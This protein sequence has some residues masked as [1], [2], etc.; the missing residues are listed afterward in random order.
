MTNLPQSR[1]DT[2]ELPSKIALDTWQDQISV[3][4]DARVQ[5]I[6]QDGFFASVNAW[7]VDDVGIGYV[8]ASAQQFSRSR[9]KIARDGMDGYVL[10]FYS[11]GESMSRGGDSVASPADL[12]LLDMAQP[13]A[14]VTTEHAQLSIAVPRRLLSPLL[15]AADDCHELV[16][17][18]H[19]P[20]VSLLRDTCASFARNLKCM[21]TETARLALPSIL[22][23]AAAAVNAE[24][25]EEKEAAVRTALADA[26]RR[27]IEEN[28]LEPDLS[29]DSVM[30]TF[31]MS[32]RTLYR[33]FEAL[34][35]F[36]AYLQKQR[37]RHA[38]DALRAP[39][40][41]HRS[42]SEIA[43][44]HGFANPESFTRNFRSL[45]NVT[46]REARYLPEREVSTHRSAKR[47]TDW[48]QWILQIGR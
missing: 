22:Q 37:L 48:S 12:Y 11:H 31:G 24:V 23:L 38:W 7:L 36:N 34:G 6:E 39:E 29:V 33:L 44:L 14:T 28:L 27:H 1:F 45:F 40:L 18:A 15:K 30:R 8:G 10:Q 2:R 32:R 42:I 5:K 25:D 4:F 43:Q 16:L 13:L 19:L 35:G 26:V 3:L 9:H 17:P 47:P 46:P 41:R 21:S 20:L